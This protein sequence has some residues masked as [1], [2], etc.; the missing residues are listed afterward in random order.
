[1]LVMVIMKLV[2]KLPFGGDILCEHYA[3][4]APE[5]T[6]P[7]AYLEKKAAAKAAKEDKKAA[8]GDFAFLNDSEKAE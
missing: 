6:F 3:E 8:K 7:A 4:D 1:M 5:V 2:K